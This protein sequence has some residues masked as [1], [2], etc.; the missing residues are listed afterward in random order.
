MMQ[1]KSSWF[2]DLMIF[3]LI[4]IYVSAYFTP[5]HYGVRCTQES[6]PLGS[7]IL[8]VFYMFWT[9]YTVR[10]IRN[11]PLLAVKK[12]KMGDLWATT[13]QLSLHE[14]EGEFNH[15]NM[16]LAQRQMFMI[17]TVINL[18]I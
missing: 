11:D 13:K 1:S 4:A 18:L 2:I 8:C 3:I 14:F 16:V 10:Y 7:L 9:F 6:S 17:T 15:D 5:K 12:Q